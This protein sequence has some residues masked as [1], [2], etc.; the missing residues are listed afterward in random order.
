MLWKGL[1]LYYL[2]HTHRRDGFRRPEPFKYVTTLHKACEDAL[3]AVIT[4][5]MAL[6]AR[7]ILLKVSLLMRREKFSCDYMAGEWSAKVPDVV[8]QIREVD[9]YMGQ[10]A[11]VEVCIEGDEPNSGQ[12]IELLNELAKR[13]PQRIEAYLKLWSLFYDKGCY[14]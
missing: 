7:Y 4:P 14:H 8:K 11:K 12:A 10:L 6:T 9:S 5:D 3:K 13:Y 2:L 1:I